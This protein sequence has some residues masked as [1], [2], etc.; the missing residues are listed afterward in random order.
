MG[1][2]FGMTFTDAP[3]TAT[4]DNMI[5][6]PRVP[7][8]VPPASVSTGQAA[9]LPTAAAAAYDY[10]L[11]IH[12]HPIGPTARRLLEGIVELDPPAPLVPQPTRQDLYVALTEVGEDITPDLQ[13]MLGVLRSSR[14]SDD[15]A[16]L[17]RDRQWQASMAA[18]ADLLLGHLASARVQIATLRR[19]NATLLQQNIQATVRILELTALPGAPVPPPPPPP[20]AQPPIASGSNAPQQEPVSTR[21][22]APPTAVRVAATSS[23]SLTGASPTTPGARSPSS[24]TAR[25]VPPEVQGSPKFPQES[26]QPS[27]S[28]TG[29]SRGEHDAPSSF[30]TATPSPPAIS[31][32]PA[33]RDVAAPFETGSRT[34]DVK[35]ADAR[36]PPPAASP[37]GASAEASADPRIE[38]DVDMLDGDTTPT[39]RHQRELRSGSGTPTPGEQRRHSNPEPQRSPAPP[40]EDS[41][42]NSVPKVSDPQSPAGS[43]ET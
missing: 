14:E 17:E 37:S 1:I 7:V 3:P 16:V 8:A 34:P 23:G 35:M 15:P 2:V 40:A 22:D 43:R 39:Q 11:A 28:Q 41:V 9:A 13:Q 31:T 36:T 19:T 32:S 4:F 5:S 20:A 26:P 30:P 6:A 12:T 10:H 18:Q 25:V 42:D 33:P 38:E 24:S 27:P 29:P 21:T